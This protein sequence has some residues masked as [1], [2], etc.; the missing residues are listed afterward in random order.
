M[1]NTLNLD[2][3]TENIMGDADL[4]WTDEYLHYKKM[5]QWNA[6]DSNTFQHIGAGGHIVFWCRDQYILYIYKS[7]SIKIYTNLKVKIWI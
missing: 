1:N 2:Q 4:L 7:F 5:H 6:A 3:I